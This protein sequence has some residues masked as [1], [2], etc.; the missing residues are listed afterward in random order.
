[1]EHK[2]LEGYEGFDARDTT[3]AGAFV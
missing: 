2:T 3:H 1:V